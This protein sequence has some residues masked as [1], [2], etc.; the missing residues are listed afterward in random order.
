MKKF[1]F[2]LLFVPLVSIGQTVIYET[3]KSV[4]NLDTWDVTTTVTSDT[5][6]IT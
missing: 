1:L 3:Y 4:E 2:V 6:N 5:L